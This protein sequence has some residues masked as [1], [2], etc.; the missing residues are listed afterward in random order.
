MGNRRNRLAKLGL[1]N[2]SDDEIAALS[3]GG[4]NILDGNAARVSALLRGKGIEISPAL[5][6]TENIDQKTLGEYQGSIYHR[7]QRAEDAESLFRLGFRDINQPDNR[8]VPPLIHA[9]LYYV[10]S[11]PAY[12]AWL[13]A[14]GAKLFQ[15]LYPTPSTHTIIPGATSAH[16]VLRNPGSLLLRPELRWGEPDPSFT[17]HAKVLSVDPCDECSCNCSQR[18]CTPFIFMLKGAVGWQRLPWCAESFRNPR[19]YVFCEAILYVAEDIKDIQDEQWSLLEV[20][21]KLIR[22][23]EGNIDAILQNDASSLAGIIDFWTRHW[24]NRTKEEIKNLEG[25]NLSK[26]ER[27]AAEEVGV[28]WN[29]P[30]ASSNLSKSGRKRLQFD[31]YMRM[32]DKI[33]PD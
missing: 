31:D 18:G 29:D 22:E 27:R 23:F 21:G 11:L 16:Y 4:S 2:F 5:L 15:H 32:L 7:I 13:V 28:V 17:F 1:D 14:R 3:L 8:G 12:S 30:D 6:L 19:W 25:S 20:V 33:V 24:P 10:E 9:T 26:D